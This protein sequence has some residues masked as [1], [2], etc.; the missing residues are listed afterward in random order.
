MTRLRF[1]RMY[2]LY[3]LVTLVLG[4]YLCYAGFGGVRKRKVA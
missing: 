4:A 3:A 1:E 2:P